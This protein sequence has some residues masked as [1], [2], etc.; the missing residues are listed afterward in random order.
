M[1]S[2]NFSAYVNDQKSKSV[3][4]ANGSQLR[5]K[6]TSHI[7]IKDRLSSVCVSSCDVKIVKQ[8]RKGLGRKLNQEKNHVKL[9]DDYT[10]MTR[11]RCENCLSICHDD[12]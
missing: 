7:F 5:R 6:M 12:G 10:I 11:Q 9:F 8:Q 3:R 2:R 4:G 1:P